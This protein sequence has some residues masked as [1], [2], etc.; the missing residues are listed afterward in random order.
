M[1]YP[2]PM[3]EVPGL[4]NEGQ[5]RASGRARTI[6]GGYPGTSQHS[7]QESIEPRRARGMST[8]RRKGAT[9]FLALVAAAGGDRLRAQRGSGS[10][11]AV[12]ARP[13]AA[14]T[15]YMSGRSGARTRASTR[16]APDYNTG[17]VG[18]LYETLFRYDPLKDKFIPWLATNGKWVGKTLRRDAPQGREVERRQAVHGGGRQVHVRDR[19]ARG[20][21]VLDDVE[22]GLSRINDE[23]QH[24]QLRVLGARR[25]SRSGT[26]TCTRSRSCRGTSGPGTARPR[27]RPGTPTPLQ[28]G[29]TGPFRYGGRRRQLAD[30]PVQPA[31]TTG[32][33]RSSSASPCR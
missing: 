30:A 33:R 6:R 26:S 24:R 10:G 12:S 15:L 22:D 11:F 29:R 27:S 1:D 7:W 23:G 32:G 31:R 2:I 13:P 17:T 18:L 28:A 25:T 21:A 9:V 4:R 16:S 20:L 14:E 8:G 19:Q 5:S 3:Q